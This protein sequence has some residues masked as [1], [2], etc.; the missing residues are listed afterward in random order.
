MQLKI[1][2]ISL[3]FILLLA[4]AGIFLSGY[5]L[6]HQ[7]AESAANVIIQGKDSIIKVNTAAIEGLLHS[8]E[9]NGQTIFFLRSENE[10][11]DTQLRD[12]ITNA[13]FCAKIVY[14]D[15]CL[16]K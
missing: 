11:M 8:S 12:I 6:G 16:I 4:I 10:R 1:K 7:K 9:R 3:I 5:T 15:T 13:H 14:I 2:T